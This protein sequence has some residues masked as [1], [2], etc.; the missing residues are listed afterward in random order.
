MTSVRTFEHSQTK[1]GPTVI[2][3]GGNPAMLPRF[4]GSLL[5]EL[6]QRGLN[7]VALGNAPDERVAAALA[8]DGIVYRHYPLKPTGLNPLADFRS[9]SALVAIFREL[10]PVAVLGYALKPALYCA[11]AGKLAGTPRR[12]S[13]IEGLGYAFTPG[14]EP[15]RLIAKVIAFCLFQAFLPLATRLVVL[16]SDDARFIDRVLRR[17]R[18]PV[19]QLGGIGVDL[20]AFAPQPLPSGPVTFVLIARLLRDKGVGEYVRAAEMVRARRADARFILVGPADPNPS[21]FPIETALEWHA[22]GTVE[23]LGPLD[24]V[25]PALARAHVVVLPSYR[26][27]FPVTLME[28]MAM[29]RAALASDVPGCREAVLD[30]ISGLLVPA[31]SAEALANAMIKLID[32]ADL[33]KTLAAGAKNEARDRFDQNRIARVTADLLFDRSH[34]P[35]G[36]LELSR[37]GVI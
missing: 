10:T 17:R 3:C 4:R 18:P 16:N 5:R 21:G 33:L 14:R 30:G 24:D 27:G 2:V 36:D 15:K 35:S 29:G 25:R 9:V 28:G 23:Y 6:V 12:V 34:P 37:R 11:F 22:A 32:D 31:R 13:M 8:A 20:S 7:V 19:S 1:Q 26:E